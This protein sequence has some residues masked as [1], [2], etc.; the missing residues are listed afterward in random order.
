MEPGALPVRGGAA[1]RD[2]LVRPGG[3]RAAR[4]LALGWWER[5]YS[6]L[7]LKLPDERLTLILLAN[8]EGLWWGN[9]LDA[10]EVERSPFA[11]AFLRRFP[12][13]SYVTDACAGL[14]AAVMTISSID[15]MGTERYYLSR[16]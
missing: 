16:R 4:R 3:G 7:Y 14:F 12:P 9:P 13:R 6:A 1:V 5:A 10:A 11:A 15:A 8:S 2:R